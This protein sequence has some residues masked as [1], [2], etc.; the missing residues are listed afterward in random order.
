MSEQPDAIN[1]YAVIRSVILNES[2]KVTKKSTTSPK[3]K[4][5][6]VEQAARFERSLKKGP[7]L[8]LMNLTYEL[9]RHKFLMEFAK[10][11]DVLKFD[12]LVR[13]KTTMNYCD[14]IGFSFQTE[15]DLPV[16]SEY[17]SK[18]KT[19]SG[20]L[21]PKLYRGKT[22]VV[23]VKPQNSAILK[24]RAHDRDVVPSLLARVV[25]RKTNEDLL[26]ID[27]T[28]VR[29]YRTE[30]LFGIETYAIAYDWLSVVEDNRIMRM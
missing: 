8:D 12:L 13:S 4:Q 7:N 26:A 23:Q 16:F 9:A 19:T 18:M 29:V 27:L 17:L 28:N 3:Q 15:G 25:D 10:V 2:I 30:D 20:T 14:A 6:L 11:A 24:V 22:L 1:M 5:F 21:R